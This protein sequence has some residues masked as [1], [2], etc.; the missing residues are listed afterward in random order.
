MYSL[1]EIY[2]KEF[3]KYIILDK[4]LLKNE[5]LYIEICEI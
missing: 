3:W 2:S 1:N 5:E 4:N